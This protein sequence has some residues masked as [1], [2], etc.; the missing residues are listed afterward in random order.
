MSLVSIII[1]TRNRS[2]LAKG[3]VQNVL[4]QTYTDIEII[5]VEDGSKSGIDNYLNKLNDTRIHY[6]SHHKRRGLAAARNSGAKIA[7]GKYLSFMDDDE[8]WCEEKTYLQYKMF[9]G[10]DNEKIMIYCGNFILNEN[11]SLNESIPKAKGRMSKYFFYGYCIGSSCMMIPR[12]NFLSI[13]GQSENL[14]SCIDHDFWL[15]LSLSGFRMDFVP[16]GLVY[17]VKHNHQRMMDDIDERLK[18]IQY[19][20]QKWRNIVIKEAGKKAWLNIEKIYHVQ[21]AHMVLDQY[22]KRNISKARLIKAINK[23][24]QIQLQKY[25][26]LDVLF[27]RYGKIHLT[28]IKNSKKK[29]VSSLNRFIIER[30]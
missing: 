4:K 18:G 19:F 21:T 29:T 11:G 8:R 9:K 30:L 25:I 17:S 15:K 20:F 7:N 5:V 3:A 24:L 10:C 13:G 14:I 2:D 26:W 28:P 23:L 16:K 6:F 1:P 12:E 27:L 22:R